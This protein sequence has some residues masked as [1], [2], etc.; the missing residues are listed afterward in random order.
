MET[1]L[2]SELL[3]L[4]APPDLELAKDEMDAD[5]DLE[6]E[7]GVAD[8]EDVTATDSSAKGGSAAAVAAA[9]TDEQGLVE[10]SLMAVSLEA[11]DST[12]VLRL[13]DSLQLPSVDCLLSSSLVFSTILLSLSLASGSSLSPSEP[14][15]LPSDEDEADDLLDDE[16]EERKK[17]LAVQSPLS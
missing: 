15:L 7:V 5:G 17:W 14:S 2:G 13:T 1:S 16:D 12:E 4:T 3:L 8:A 11:T 10:T 9:V 6:D